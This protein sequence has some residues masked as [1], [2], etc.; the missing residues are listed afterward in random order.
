ML[1]EEPRLQLYMTPF[2]GTAETRLEDLRCVTPDADQYLEECN[3]A[4][5]MLSID[6]Y[7][8]E[9]LPPYALDNPIPPRKR[10]GG[11]THS[12]M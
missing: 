3:A 10:L 7:T 4:D 5:T 2:E 1:C 12:L 8:S 6:Q 11:N 9:E